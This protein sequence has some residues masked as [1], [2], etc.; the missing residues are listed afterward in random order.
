MV[1]DDV[2]NDSKSIF[3]SSLIFGIKNLRTI[4]RK[5][6][7]DRKV[8]AIVRNKEEKK[9]KII[10]SCKVKIKDIFILIL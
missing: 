1:I 8:N 4:S 9:I 3:F 5:N 6:I 7:N 2:F 10:V